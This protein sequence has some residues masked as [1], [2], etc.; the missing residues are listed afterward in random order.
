MSSC[1]FARYRQSRNTSALI[2]LMVPLTAKPEVDAPLVKVDKAALMLQC[3]GV[4]F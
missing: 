3:R 1:G 2:R 4:S